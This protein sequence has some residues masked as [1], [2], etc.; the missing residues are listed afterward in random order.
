[1]KEKYILLFLITVLLV[2]FLQFLKVY[3]FI[4]F[5]IGYE[6]GLIVYRWLFNERN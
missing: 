2:M 1:M 5:I 6:L 3:N 4:S